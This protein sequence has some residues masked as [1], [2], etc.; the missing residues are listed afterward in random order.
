MLEKAADLSMKEDGC[1]DGVGHRQ[2]CALEP[3][4][5]EIAQYPNCFVGFV[6]PVGG[7]LQLDGIPDVIR[8][9]G[10]PNRR[11]PEVDHERS[12]FCSHTHP[13]FP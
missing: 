5:E 8:V 12:Y 6:R 3:V 1:A 11:Q 10:K 4:I 2:A 9:D 7:Q 13:I